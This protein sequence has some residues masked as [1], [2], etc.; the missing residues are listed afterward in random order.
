MQTNGLVSDY[1][2]LGRGT[3]QSLLLSPLL[4]SLATEPVT[5]AIHGATDFLGVT[6]Q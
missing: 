4:F 2:M 5:S 3:R 1:I 6:V